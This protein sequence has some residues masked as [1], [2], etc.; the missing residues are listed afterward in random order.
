[1]ARLYV[2]MPPLS[3][4]ALGEVPSSTISRGYAGSV[5]AADVIKAVA[6]PQR[7]RVLAAVALGAASRDQVGA[8]AG[9]DVRGVVT[10]TARLSATGLLADGPNGLR[11]DYEKLRELVRSLDVPVGGEDGTGLAR[12]VQDGRLRGLPSKRAR[13]HAVLAHIVETSFDEGTSYDE[14]AVNTVL[15]RWCEGSGVDHVAIRRYLIDH[16]LL[17][18]VRNVYARSAD[19][20]PAPGEAERYMSAIGL[21]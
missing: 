13:R 1:M 5:E 11:V 8:M 9:V 6:D 12:F 2:D 18:R 17:F 21:D 10:A 19:V 16:Q 14:A 15:E 3:G 7:F 20:L 4:A